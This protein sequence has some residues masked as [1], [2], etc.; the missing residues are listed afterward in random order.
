M[1]LLAS[2]RVD[3]DD[4][5]YRVNLSIWDRI[6]GTYVDQPE[7]RH[8]VMTIGLKQCQDDSPARLGRS[9]ALPFPR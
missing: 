1:I 7:R 5:N 8:D 2:G 4:A 3:E 9:L 6:F